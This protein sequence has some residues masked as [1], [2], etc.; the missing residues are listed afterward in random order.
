[1]VPTS[2]RTDMTRFPPVRQI[3][4]GCF[5]ML[6]AKGR[7]QSSA[8]MNPPLRGILKGVPPPPPPPPPRAR[9]R[10]RSRSQEPVRR[11]RS[12]SLPPAEAL[13]AAAATPVPPPS[14]A[15]TAPTIRPLARPTTPNE[16]VG[17]FSRDTSSSQGARRSKA[18]AK[19]N[20]EKPKRT[21]QQRTVAAVATDGA[22]VRRSRSLPPSETVAA[23][24]AVR[25][26]APSSTS[27]SRS[28]ALYIATRR[29]SKRGGGR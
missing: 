27:S 18:K 19:A 6:Y 10:S 14:T 8:G 17:R 7:R 3:C 26:A 28:R 12:R 29:H 21:Q 2:R 22:G 11:Q 15:P 23:N 5:N 20:E 13:P 25:A 4:D 9:S 1:M 24:Y 16:R